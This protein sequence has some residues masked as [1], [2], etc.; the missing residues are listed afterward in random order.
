M[1]RPHV[2]QRRAPLADPRV[3][4]RPSCRFH[5]GFT[6]TR[7][8]DHA[9]MHSLYA[10]PASAAFLGYAGMTS[11]PVPKLSIEH[12]K[13][14]SPHTLRN[15]MVGIHMRNKK[16]LTPARVSN[17]HISQFVHR[18]QQQA[19]IFWFIHLFTYWNYVTAH[20]RKVNNMRWNI[21][22]HRTSSDQTDRLN[23]D[24]RR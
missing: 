10:C 6:S 2:S 15:S 13:R 19:N 22:E 21:A 3:P 18:L 23:N 9:S 17:T 14:A 4:S 11:S 5:A 20:R 8:P 16:L 1:R 7:R 24:D 12:V